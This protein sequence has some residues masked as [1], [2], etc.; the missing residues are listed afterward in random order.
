MSRQE[1]TREPHPRAAG[2]ERI[3][4][5]L[6]RPADGTGDIIAVCDGGLELHVGET[7]EGG[8]RPGQGWRAGLWAAHPSLAEGHA[9][10]KRTARELGDCLTKSVR[11]AGHWWE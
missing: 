5:S 2:I 1:T 6:H 4:V 10:W 8:T 7:A 3:R 9:T 11:A